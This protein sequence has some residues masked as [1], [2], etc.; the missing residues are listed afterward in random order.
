M[1]PGLAQKLLE[2]VG[3][4]NLPKNCQRRLDGVIS[5]KECKNKTLEASSNNY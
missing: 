5:L 3:W 4:G 1:G 2:E